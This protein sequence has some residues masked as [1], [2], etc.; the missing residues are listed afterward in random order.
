MIVYV[1]RHIKNPQ[2]LAIKIQKA[3]LNNY[4]IEGYP[5]GYV[6]AQLPPHIIKILFKKQ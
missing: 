2:T 1:D 4:D 5:H 3:F 6:V